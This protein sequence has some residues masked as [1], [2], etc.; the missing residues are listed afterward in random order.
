MVETP[1]P[2]NPLDRMELAR[3]VERALLDRPL[4][5][6]P[7]PTRFNGAGLYAIY[8][9]GDFPAYA[10][11][12]PPERAPGQMPI[13]VG[14]AQPKGARQ[15]LMTGLGVSTPEPVLFD[16]L[17]EHANSIRAV[18]R[19]TEDGQPNLRLDDFRCRH[20]VVDDIW[21]A[22]GEAIL[23]GHYRPLWNVVVDGFGNHAPGSGRGQQARSP[24]DEVHPGRGWAFK[25]PPPKRPRMRV[26]TQI[27][28]HLAS[29]AAPDLTAD[30]E[31]G[32]AIQQ[33]LSDG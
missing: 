26:L 33:A 19:H 13:Y 16:R 5:P 10:R 20:L 4:G 28:E 24:W 17:R 15:G 14:R 22:L 27:R 30:P 1:Q 9:V 31:W 7:P 12:T 32:P 18:E 25:L 6:L 3:S 23:I 8:Y 29:L 2:Y 11:I 21:V